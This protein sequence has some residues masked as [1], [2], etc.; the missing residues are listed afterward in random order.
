MCPGPCWS[1]KSDPNLDQIV[2]RPRNPS[3]QYWADFWRF[4]ELL[5][6]LA[7]RDLLVRYKQTTIGLFWAV[8]R[9]LLA[10]VILTLVFRKFGNLP[11]GAAPYPAM[12]LCGLL[13]W[14]LFAASM[15]ESGN[16]LVNS[17]GLISKVFFPRLIVPVSSLISGCVDFLISLVLLFGLLLFYGYV[18]SSN[19]IFLPFFVLLAVT[20]SLAVGIGL[21]ALLVMYR[22][23]RFVIP[24][25]VQ[26]GLY[27]SPVGMQSA[28]VPEAYRLLYSLNPLVGIIDGFRW[29]I[30]GDAY[31][32]S[33][34]SLAVAVGGVVL[35]LVG[36]VWYFR[37]VERF[38][39][40]II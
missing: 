38:F 34:P 25:A 5:G 14:Q 2:I 39:A 9:P 19:L 28:V 16:S 18:P 11:S 31:P 6:F 24:F 3:V 35:M 7:W 20:A 37:R 29:S 15:S 17:S 26:M 21:S 13:P 32:L 36:S 27:V 1:L 22:D 8:L 4:R 23:V 10:M 33:L 40:D 12:V 30:L